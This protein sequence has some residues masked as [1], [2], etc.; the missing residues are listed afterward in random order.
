MG[1]LFRAPLVMGVGGQGG[2]KQDYGGQFKKSLPLTWKKDQ[3]A[4]GK[5][6]LCILKMTTA[7]LH[8]NWTP[9]FYFGSKS[10]FYFLFSP[11]M[12]AIT[13][14]LSRYFALNKKG[15]RGDCLSL[16]IAL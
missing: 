14:Q 16:Q 7:D 4:W 15:Q 9:S 8:T 5:V 2:N 1:C 11:L 6:Q 3:E 12:A 13:L 10:L